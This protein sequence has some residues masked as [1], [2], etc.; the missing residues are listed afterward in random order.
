MKESGGGVSAAAFS[1]QHNG[2]SLEQ[3]RLTM[4]DGLHAGLP[5]IERKNEK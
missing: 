4:V 2:D 3:Y 1:Y 5:V